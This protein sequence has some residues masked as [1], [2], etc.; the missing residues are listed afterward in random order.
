MFEDE[1]THNYDKL[2]F[3]QRRT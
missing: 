1:E 2:G 3:N